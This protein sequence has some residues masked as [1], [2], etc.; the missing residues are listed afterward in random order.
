M[1]L[2]MRGTMAEHHGQKSIRHI[3]ITQNWQK[4]YQQKGCS[5]MLHKLL[6]MIKSFKE[7]KEII[8]LEADEK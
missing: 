1:V 5:T 6:I 8:S 7:F 3:G 2:C 4:K